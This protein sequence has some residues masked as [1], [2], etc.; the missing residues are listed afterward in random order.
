VAQGERRMTARVCV[1]SGRYDDGGWR[2]YGVIKRDRRF[3]CC[4]GSERVSSGCSETVCMLIGVYF[5]V[6]MFR[7]LYSAKT[8]F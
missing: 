3:S 5:H 4:I 6:L 7:F 1:E 8:G 2:A